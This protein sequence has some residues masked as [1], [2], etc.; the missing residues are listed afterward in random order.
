MVRE[1]DRSAILLYFHN[2]GLF[3]KVQ[4]YGWRCVCSIRVYSRLESVC[5]RVS[6]FSI[7]RTIGSESAV[8]LV[9]AVRKATPELERGRFYIVAQCN[10]SCDAV[11]LA[12]S[13][14]LHFA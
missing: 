13:F 5:S 4:R 11:V 6:Y 8:L 1:L 3:D 12:I 2:Q 10:I 9:V 7:E 14:R